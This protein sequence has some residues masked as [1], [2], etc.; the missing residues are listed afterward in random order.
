MENTRQRLL[1]VIIISV[2]AVCILAYTSPLSNATS[3]LFEDALEGKVPITDN[4]P[5]GQKAEEG[6]AQAQFD[7]GNIYSEAKLETEAAKW[8]HKAAEQGHVGAQFKLGVRYE[9]GAGVPRNY[10]EAYFWL[11]LSADRDKAANDARD[12]VKRRLTAK[13]ITSIQKRAQKW[14]AAHAPATETTR[15]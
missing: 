7:L 1:K 4:R 3:F 6:D 14:K 13:Q 10:E 5:I 2:L 15:H 8:W 12:S 11:V 9:T